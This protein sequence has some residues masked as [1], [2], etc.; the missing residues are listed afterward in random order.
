MSWHSSADP[1]RT[2]LLQIRLR[3]LE[4]AFPSRLEPA[5]DLCMHC[6]EHIAAIR[7][8]DRHVR[9]APRTALQEASRLSFGHGSALVHESL[10]RFAWF[11]PSL[12][13]MCLDPSSEGQEP[14][15]P[16]DVRRLV[17][18]AQSVE[19]VKKP[20]GRSTWTA[21]EHE[22][23]RDVFAAALSA[24]LSTPPSS[25]ADPVPLLDL[26]QAFGVDADVLLDVWLGDTTER[27]EANLLATFERAVAGYR[28]GVVKDASAVAVLLFGDRV[29]RRLE[30]RFFSEADPMRAARLAEAEAFVRSVHP[31]AT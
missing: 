2:T 29:R 7:T 27:A 18:E 23:I 20:D 14:W 21:A 15:S 30:D 4:A 19:S 31:G 6:D 13:S 24:F 17:S 1:D 9:D 16:D 26:A 3:A 28:M 22:A 12:L 11:V 8:F 25:D 10:R 5:H